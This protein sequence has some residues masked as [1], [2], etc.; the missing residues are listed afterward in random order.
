VS[1]TTQNTKSKAHENFLGET[2]KELDKEV[3][4]KLKEARV[5]LLFNAP[6][7][8]SM[9]LRLELTNA[10]QWLPTAATD[11][12]KFYYNSRFI[13]KLKTEEIEFLF[14]HEV[15]HCCYDHLGRT[16]TRDRQL[17]NIA[18]DYA[19]NRDL[20]KHKIGTMIT[21]VDC[22]YDSKY[23]DMSA[24]EIYD[25]L[26]EN[27]EKIDMDDLINKMIDEHLEG[28][29]NE[30]S[31]VGK[32]GNGND[33]G[34]G[35]S[36]L[37]KEDKE[38]IKNEIKESMIQA[39][40]MTNAVTP[41]GV[42]RMINDLTNPKMDWEELLRQSLE[43]AIKTDFSWMKTSRRGWHIDAILPGMTPGKEVDI[44]VAIDTSGSISDSMLNNFLSEV[45]GIMDCFTAFKI[46]LFAFDTEVHNPQTFTSD[47][48]DDMSEYEIMGHGGTDFECV[49]KY[50]I[51]EGIEPERLVMFT[52]MYPWDNNW[53]EENYCDTL[54]I[55]HGTTTIEAPYGVTTY[56]DE[57]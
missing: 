25:V 36:T 37:S 2:D 53:G 44:V 27:A 31:S 10:D 46:H 18:C 56:Y 35:P 6:F 14:G 39:S 15:L 3:R 51:K 24:E 47:N 22:L 45:Q 16:D 52:D 42:A 21:T 19:V 23:N 50:L 48:L 33:E 20:M 13:D 7:F 41:A 12:R 54:F 55:A 26:Y 28:D 34:N 29:E 49:F 40:Q 30:E 1:S 8:G 38:E 5:G 57:N 17:F 4:E 32:N 43:S 9:A 11:G